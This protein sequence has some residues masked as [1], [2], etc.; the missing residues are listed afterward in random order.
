M[1]NDGIRANFEDIRELAF[2]SIT[3]AYAA[4]G[5]ATQGNPRIVFVGND[6][7]IDVYITND[8]TNDKW[9]VKANSFRLLDIASNKTPYA[10]LFI[11]KLTVFSARRV[12][13]GVA[14][15]SGGIWLEITS[16][17]GGR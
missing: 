4:V 8:G 14:A 11:D 17:E 7:D 13:A 9:K 3:A 6:S 12:V 1:S 10:P 5:V 15:T 16:A 2:G